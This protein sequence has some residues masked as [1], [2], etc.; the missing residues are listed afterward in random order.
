MDFCAVRRF[1]QVTILENHKE[2]QTDHNLQSDI[3]SMIKTI[4]KQ[5]SEL[6]LTKLDCSEDKCVESCEQGWEKNGDHCYSWNTA[7]SAKKNW[8][9]AEDFC[10]KEGGHLASI[11]SNVTNQYVVEKVERTGLSHVWF[12][13]KR[14]CRGGRLEVDRLQSL[15]IHIVVQ[16][17]TKQCRGKPELL[18]EMVGVGNRKIRGRSLRPCCCLCLQQK[19]LCR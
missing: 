12:G 13:R 8:T 18:G 6:T 7:W 15:G 11:T 19:N 3:L 16:R 14:H 10:Q 1:A 5:C 2:I 9:D 17:T 4:L